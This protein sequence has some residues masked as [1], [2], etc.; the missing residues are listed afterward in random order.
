MNGKNKACR[1]EDIKVKCLD[2]LN[3]WRHFYRDYMIPSLVNERKHH[4]VTAI[5]NGKYR[6]RISILLLNFY[7]CSVL[8][9]GGVL[10]A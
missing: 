3:Y 7:L 5:N 4:N 2:K 10:N 6:E 8:S 9:K 1:F